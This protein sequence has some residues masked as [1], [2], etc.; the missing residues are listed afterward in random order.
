MM[1]FKTCFPWCSVILS[2][3]YQIWLGSCGLNFQPLFSFKS[4][5]E[6]NQVASHSSVLGVHL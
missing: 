6:E 5:Y 2:M 4:R 3:K 1:S